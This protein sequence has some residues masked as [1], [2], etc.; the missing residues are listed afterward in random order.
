MRV[1]LVL[2]AEDDDQI[3]AE[4]ERLTDADWRGTARGVPALARALHLLG[5]MLTKLGIGLIRSHAGQ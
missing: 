1:V 5:Q 2:A 3:L 4:T